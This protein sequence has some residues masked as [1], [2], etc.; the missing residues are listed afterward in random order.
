LYILRFIRKLSQF[1]LP[2]NT[3]DVN[4]PQLKS[5]AEQSQT[6]L[7]TTTTTTSTQPTSPYSYQPIHPPR[8]LKTHFFE[9]EKYQQENIHEQSSFQK[10]HDRTNDLQKI[11]FFLKL[12][13][14]LWICPF[15]DSLS[16]KYLN[17]QFLAQTDVIFEVKLIIQ[18]IFSTVTTTG[19]DGDD[20]DRTRGFQK[21]IKIRF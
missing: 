7:P 20:F 19:G 15:S 5:Y 11:D 3:R 17:K 21:K 13:I 14:D 16:E 8:L 10:K 6:T 4:F 1:F 9:N 2:I 12:L 18:H